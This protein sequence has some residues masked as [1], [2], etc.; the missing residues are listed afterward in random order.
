MQCGAGKAYLEGAPTVMTGGA[1]SFL[2]TG[3]LDSAVVQ[4]ELVHLGLLLSDGAISDGFAAVL[5]E[6]RCA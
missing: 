2:A 5:A 6:G 3:P 4:G 1:C